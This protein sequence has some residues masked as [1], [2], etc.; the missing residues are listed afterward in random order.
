MKRSFV[1]LALMVITALLVVACGATATPTTVQPPVVQTVVVTSVVE[2]EGTPQV[3]TNTVEVV[4]TAV[5]P[6]V[7]VE[8]P[9]SSDPS[10]Y[11]LETFGDPE[12]LDPALNYE[13]AGAGIIQQ[14]YEGL[15]TYN[16]ENAAEYVPQLA[17]EMPEVSEDG[18]TYT[19]TIREGITFHEG[20]ELTAEDVAYS[21]QRGL[22][23]GGYSSPQLLFT[24]PFLGVGIYDITEVVFA[25]ALD[26][27]GDPEALRAADPAA[28]LAACELVQSAI[29][30]DGNT[31]TFTLAQP[32]SP[33]VSTMAGGWGSIMDKE[34]VIENG[35]WDGECA[36]WQDFYGIA[37]ENDPFTAI[38][39]GT[40]PYILERWTPGEEIVLV[41]NEN[42]WR[43]EETGPAWEGGPVGPPAIS[44]VV[45][46]SVTEWGTRFAS[47]QA[48]DADVVTVPPENRTQVDPLV[49]E[50][51]DFN[52]DTLGFDCAATDNP[53]GPLR[54]F[55]GSPD[56]T[57]SDM[58]FTW[59]INVD[60][61]NPLVGSGALDG[62]GV[63]PDF[64]TD[65]NVRRG[66]AYC[67]DWD[68]LINE[69]YQGEAVQNV[70]PIIPGMVG[71]NEDG[72]R[73]SFDLD[74]CKEELAT[75]W[76]GVLPETGFRVQVAYNTGN[77][78]RQVIGEILQANL[79]AASLDNPTPGNYVVEVIGLPWANFL[80]NQRE[81]R[82]PIF[83]S[84]WHED[85]HDPHNWVQPFLVGVY[86]QRMGLPEE[87]TA[88]FAELIDSA[89]VLTDPAE[90]QPIY[91]EITQL[92]YDNVVGIRLV[93][94]GIRRYEQ[95]WVKGWYY[96]PAASATYY[97]A[98]SK[99]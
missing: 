3:V 92:D 53:T 18:L 24:E 36:T 45:I 66:F 21:Y 44:T 58:M 4:V 74:A 62:N 25:D 28:L 33:L 11:Y 40:G 48:G 17:A 91:E 6:E 16:R 70:G 22:L 38:T 47:L 30:A 75:A 31:V 59:N 35:G 97:Y 94:P 90:R 80:R 29:V 79:D 95:R 89:V 49:G 37:S 32:W 87:L 39:N 69:V 27:A 72:P 19:F 1:T 84:G 93:L 78:T 77:T 65:I 14:T 96:N 23:Q 54:L 13:S 10:T 8:D 60:G 67:F 57:R 9:A 64:F 98:I 71:Y 99:D 26:S 56:V 85:I 7:V 15:V 5:P 73:Y 63:P 50:Q 12:T 51:C 76:G 52:F 82:L 68:I 55:R 2:V 46:K 43:N 34:W 81:G 20:G 41:G 86:A 88:Q 83:V 61:G 42:Y